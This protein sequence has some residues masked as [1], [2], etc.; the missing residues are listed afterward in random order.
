MTASTIQT[1]SNVLPLAISTPVELGRVLRELGQIDEKLN[2][3]TIKNKGAKSTTI[4]KLSNSTSELVKSIN[5]DIYDQ[6]I[7]QQLI[8]YLTDIK[9]KAPVM[10]VSFSSEASHQFTMRIVSWLRKEV[11]P[12]ALVVVGL[13][14]TI[15]AGSKVRTNN[16]YFDFSLASRLKK[17]HSLLA[18]KI[19]EFTVSEKPVEPKTQQVAAKIPTPLTKGS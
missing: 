15:G 1:N 16:H 6:H 10:H 9:H 4:V 5:A 2:Q 19:K 18:D 13:D 7:R 8:A 11:N 3:E 14:P 17:N 12:N